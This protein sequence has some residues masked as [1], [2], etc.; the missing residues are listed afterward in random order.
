MTKTLFAA[1]MAM[2]L[3]CAAQ[4]A[5]QLYF[6]ED[7][8]PG[9]SVVP[10]RAPAT[11]RAAF[12]GELSGGVSNEGFERFAAGSTAPLALSFAG[13]GGS[14][15][16]ATLSGAGSISNNT[17]V[18]RFNT[19]AG[20]SKWWD[21]QGSFKIDF[22]TAVSAF[23]FYGTDIGDFN[24][25]VT[26]DLTDIA[27]ATT[28]YVVSNTPNGNDGALLFWGFVDKGNS[29][30][31]ISFGNTNAGVDGFGFDDM[32][33]GDLSQVGGGGTPEPGTLALVGL[34]L[35]GLALSSRRRRT[36]D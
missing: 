8:S 16:S 3:A 34:A 25:Q 10:G 19:T 22:G 13:S 9:A 1:V 17:S 12:L 33:V 4:A 35:G 5:P 26:I 28:R 21:V 36:R 6:G 18:G 15:L 14:T 11:A 29:Y 20:G 23:G 32:V 2:G 30:K 24:G 7:Q 27:G 31:S